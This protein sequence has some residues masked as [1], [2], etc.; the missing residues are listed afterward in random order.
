M[1]LLFTNIFAKSNNF[2]EPPA[3]QLAQASSIPVLLKKPTTLYWCRERK[4]SGFKRKKVVY[5]YYPCRECHPD[6][7]VGL[8]L[9]AETWNND[10][11]ALVQFIEKRMFTDRQIVPRSKLIPYYGGNPGEKCLE[12]KKQW[13]PD[14]VELHLSRLR[15]KASKKIKKRKLLGDETA[16]IDA[17]AEAIFLTR[18]LEC[19]FER[20]EEERAAAEH[21]EDETDETEIVNKAQ[22]AVVS[23]DLNERGSASITDGFSDCDE[24][25]F[26]SMK[27]QKKERVK[28]GDIIAYYKP[29]FTMGDQRGYSTAKVVSVDP[30]GQPVLR[31]DPPD[32]LPRDHL[33]KRIHTTYRGK[34]KDFTKN[35]TFRQIDEYSLLKDNGSESTG[36]NV[37]YI[38]RSEQF[39]C[40]IKKSGEELEK[41]ADELGMGN[42]SDLLQF[43]K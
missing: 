25:F 19:A 23:Q 27:K 18:I 21:H 3:K 35:G 28:P 29:P 1:F 22:I 16:E 42:C 14:L 40:V 12:G 41:K 30:R 8:V 9:G 24:D 11:K 31:L 36:H 13:N 39:K 15:A 32:F 10:E 4:K 37:G 6:E 17:Q 38:D 5:Q 26:Q 7:A 2:H 20:H 43:K 34:R 33:I